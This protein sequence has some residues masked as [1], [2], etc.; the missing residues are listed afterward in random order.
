M[1]ASDSK[2]LPTIGF[3]SVLDLGEGG[4]CGGYLLLNAA[5]RPLEFHCTA[6]V[7]ANRAQEILYGPTLRPFLYGEQIGQ[8]LLSRAKSP[9]MLVV[10]DCEPALAVRPFSPARVICLLQDDESEA[11]ETRRLDGG[12]AS[13]APLMLRGRRAMVER[14][15]PQ[16]A[17]A[18]AEFWPKH[19]EGFDLD[20]PF[21]RI[22]E[23]LAEASKA[24][25]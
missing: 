10:T 16:D 8:T 19:F 6:P 4:V 23:A 11:K 14:S 24:A 17:A 25:A 21:G 5:S 7:K 2:S 20:E 3:L 18:V 12:H 1:P 15:H 9:P 13:P 22:A